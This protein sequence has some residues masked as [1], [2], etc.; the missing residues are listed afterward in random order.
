MDVRDNFLIFSVSEDGC[1]GENFDRH[2]GNDK[3]SY[4]YLSKDKSNSKK[5]IIDCDFSKELA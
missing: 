5:T 3:R 4:R 2:F 1:F